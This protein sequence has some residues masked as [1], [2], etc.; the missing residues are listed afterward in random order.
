[1][2]PDTLV[3]RVCI[4]YSVNQKELGKFMGYSYDMMRKCSCRTFEMPTPM[5]MHLNAL[6]ELS[7]YGN[8]LSF[9]KT[10]HTNVV[11]ISDV[12]SRE[13]LVFP[14]FNLGV[15]RNG[16]YLFVRYVKK[17]HR[18]YLNSRSEKEIDLLLDHCI[19]KGYFEISDKDLT[20]IKERIYTIINRK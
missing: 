12:E 9:L 19:K 13:P 14:K 18:Y 3:N 10:E 4:A 17:E 2:N 5:R 16:Y 8:D 7:E 15:I 1:M 20:E 6:L 11:T